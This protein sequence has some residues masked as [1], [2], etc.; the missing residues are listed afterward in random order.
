MV[1]L[2]TVHI[3]CV[4]PLPCCEELCILEVTF[5]SEFP[6]HGRAPH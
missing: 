2:L 3:L 6:L 1:A 4:P 5:I